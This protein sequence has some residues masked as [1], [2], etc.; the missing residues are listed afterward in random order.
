[1]RKLWRQLHY[2]IH[3]R[4]IEAEL[5]EELEFHRAARQSALE[6]SGL[7][8]AAATDA[9]RR[10]VGNTL[11]AREDAR[12]VWIWPWLESVWQDVRN[13]AR[14]LRREPSFCLVVAL[15]LA[16]G[17]GLNATVFGMMDALLL[18]PFQ[19]P[20]YQRIVILR[21]LRRG[22]AER[23]PV[24]AANFLDW[25]G[26][27]RSFGTLSAWEG[28]GVNLTGRGEA[29]RLQGARVAAGFFE[30]LGVGAAVGQPFTA[31]ERSGADRR[32]VLSDA[33]WKRRFGGDPGIVGRQIVLDGEPYVVTGVAPAK[34]EF[35][36]ACEIWTPLTLS[37]DQAVERDRRTLTVIGKLAAG[38]SLDR[39][40][41]EMETIARRIAAEHPGSNRDRQVA[42][43]SLSEA[44]REDIT[45]A[46]V[47][48]LQTAAGLVL[49][50]ACANLG[51]LLLARTID[52]R[53][54]LA[55][56]AAL[57]AGRMR[58][59][60]QLVTETA[61]LALLSSALAI[62]VAQIGIDVLRASMPADAAR[63]TE[64]WYN[65]RL[66]TR[67]LLL[68]PVFAILVG[69]GVGVLPALSASP[70]N[71]T[72]ALKDGDRGTAGTL[73]RQRARQA[74]VVAEISFALAALVAA[75]LIV[76]SGARLVRQP[77]GFDPRSLLT[78]ELA[79]PEKQYASPESRHA[80][81]DRL[82]VGLA[83][84]PGVH[85]VAL[86]SILPASGWSPSTSLTVEGKPNADGAAIP[87]AG[88]QLISAGYFNAMRIPV[89]TGREFSAADRV[90]NQ[91][92]AVVSEAMAQ[93]FWPG[94]NALGRRIRVGDDGRWLTIVGVV[95][96]V[97]MYNW[98]DGVDFQRVYVPLLQTAHDGVLFAAVR[99]A[100]A[101]AAIAPS[102]RLSVQGVDPQLPIQRMRPMEIA[103]QDSSLGLNFLSVLMAICG[104]IA[105]V[106][107]MAGIYSMM[108]CSMAL[109]RH[110][111]GV[112]IALGGTARDMLT[113]A[114]KQ[115]GKLT[116]I[117]LACGSVLACLFGWALSSA[118]FGL[119]S[120][121]GTTLVAGNLVLAIVSLAAAYVPARRYAAPRSDHDSAC[122][123]I[124]QKPVCAELFT[125]VPYALCGI[126]RLWWVRRLPA[127]ALPPLCITEAELRE[128]FAIIDRALEITDEA[129]RS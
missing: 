117:G 123:R 7:S 29:E 72:D 101:P 46:I 16:L 57:G 92:V 44:F 50:V 8:A 120:L 66:D 52:R 106:L 69:V 13:A 27:A 107:A 80:L 115:A 76:A 94:D 11:L 6:T 86:S 32:V 34:F 14:A 97:T 10:S 19:F 36:V 3:R 90:G 125:T 65:L 1:M 91:P 77:G 28:W 111:F 109:R 105:G 5:E 93:R 21:E 18:R 25:R 96:N 124:T 87:M 61:L 81:V 121:D 82:L 110:E 71:L 104:G 38:A 118:L 103:I 33:L 122:L 98:W 63:Y 59:V 119:V 128:G 74:L 4:R 43:E 62:V 47:G 112:R 58:L 64:G 55:T 31:D 26:Q 79:V 83:A 48:V 42:V 17:V 75:A 37:P 108:A 22:A 53:R 88:Y 41:A 73:G 100:A 99:A 67:L 20:D 60:R 78:L 30:L 89:L 2:W 56:R 84:A 49:L 129:V 127:W 68:T 114:L 12:A 45:P 113:L 24:A 85:S 95:S 23:E 70:A 9:A 15:T 40:R 102:L 116:A 51:G 39:A 54:E 35:P 126:V